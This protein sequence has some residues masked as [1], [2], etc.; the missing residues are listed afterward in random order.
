MCQR[1]SIGPSGAPAVG[2]MLEP[3]TGITWQRQQ[4]AARIAGG[5]HGIGIR[6][7][8]LSRNAR[9]MPL[10][11][12]SAMTDFRRALPILLALVTFGAVAQTPPQA[13]QQAAETFLRGRI[14]NAGADQV[15]VT[16]T[17]LDPRLRLAPCTTPLEAFL[18]GGVEPAARTTVGVRCA[19]PYWTVY[20]PV[21]VETQMT[22]LVLKRAAPRLSPLTAADVDSQPRRL[23]GFPQSYV[24]DV[25]FPQGRHLRMPASPGTALKAEM[26]AADTLIKRGQR[27]TLLSAAGSIEVRAPGEAMSDAL[28]DGRV[29]V[30]N[31]ASRRVVEG[32]AETA[33]SV[34]VGP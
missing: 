11:L 21:T 34:R 25:G 20:V 4:A 27:V 1:G 2:G 28:P 32:V 5:E 10:A 30:Q 23:A 12:Y 24:T 29:R 14:G 9:G 33:D 26:L 15:F 19:T 13:L 16:A 7:T 18:P 3:V 6:A 22:V 8:N 31:L 17:G